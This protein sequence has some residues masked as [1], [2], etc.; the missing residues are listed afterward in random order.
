M[1]LK[2]CEVH[3][4]IRGRKDRNQP[5]LIVLRDGDNTHMLHVHAVLPVER[6][7]HSCQR[8]EPSDFAGR[9]HGQ[10]VNI[11]GRSRLTIQHRNGKPA[12]ALESDRLI[13]GL[14]DIAKE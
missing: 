4:A 5:V 14:V 1:G 13:E 7:P 11:H 10:E 12:D 3:S 9:N 2:A 8:I 6:R